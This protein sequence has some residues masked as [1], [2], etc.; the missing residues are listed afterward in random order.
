VEALTKEE[1]CAFVEK[2]I[3]D[4]QYNDELLFLLPFKTIQRV[5]EILYFD[6]RNYQVQTFTKVLQEIEK[7]VQVW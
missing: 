3:A 4:R 7:Q 5:K 1:I 2:S 6:L